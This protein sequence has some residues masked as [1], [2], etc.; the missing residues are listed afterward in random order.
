MNICFVNSTNKWGGVKSWAL[1]VARGFHAQVV[2]E[3]GA[4][5]AQALAQ[6]GLQPAGR[7]A[8]GV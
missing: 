4:T 7:I 3:N 5:K 6:H 2:G 1:D 8:G